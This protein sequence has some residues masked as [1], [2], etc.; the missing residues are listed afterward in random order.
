MHMQLNVL[1]AGSSE[2]LKTGVHATALGLA[3]VMGVYNAAAWLRRRESHLAV[4]AVLYTALTA[5]EK[6]HVAHHLAARRAAHPVDNV[7]LIAVPE[8]PAD[9]ASCESSQAFAG[10][11]ATPIRSGHEP[12]SYKVD[13]ANG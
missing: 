7:I 6:V 5:W 4:N 9:P 8:H 2:S 12:A 1:K 11:A 13:A 10:S 3:V